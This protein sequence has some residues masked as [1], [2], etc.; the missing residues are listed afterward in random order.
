MHFVYPVRTT[1]AQPQVPHE[2]AE[3]YLKHQDMCVRTLQQLRQ[4]KKDHLEDVEML[5][6][7]LA[8]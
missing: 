1:Q 8:M 4:R 6:M 2:R 3:Q 5:G 7:A